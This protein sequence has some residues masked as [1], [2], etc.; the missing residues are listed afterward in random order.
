MYLASTD[1]LMINGKFS[2]K[3]EIGDLY[4]FVL[5]SALNCITTGIKKKLEILLENE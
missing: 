4:M 2:F 3:M 5:G 1:K